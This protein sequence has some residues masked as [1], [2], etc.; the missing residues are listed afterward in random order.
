MTLGPSNP[1][2]R[3]LLQALEKLANDTGAA[4][5]V[6]EGNGLWCTAVTGTRPIGG[7]YTE[8]ADRFYRNVIAPRARDLQRGGRIEAV[9]V[10]GDDRYVAL[11]FAGIYVL[12][13]CFVAAFDVFGARAKMRAALPEIE[14]LVMMLPPSGGPAGN[15]G[16]ATKRF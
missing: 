3:R 9:K 15:E 10:D 1:A 16:A 13:L 11:S 5:V 8:L 12:V 4:F 6:D 7:S 14:R 2:W